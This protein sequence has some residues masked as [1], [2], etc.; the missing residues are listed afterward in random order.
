V[1]VPHDVRDLV[2]DFDSSTV[3]DEF[4]YLENSRPVGAESSL[5]G[6]MFFSI[7]D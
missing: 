5:D 1:W 7:S 2:V 6:K 3:G 4:S